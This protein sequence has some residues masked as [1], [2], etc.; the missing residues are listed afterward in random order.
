MK[1]I[2]PAFSLLFALQLYA[3]LPES[4]LTAEYTLTG[5]E[6][7]TDSPY[8]IAGSGTLN[9]GRD[10]QGTGTLNIN[11][12]S[13]TTNVFYGSGT[14]NVG[15][16]ATSGYLNITGTNP[17]FPE[18]QYKT[19]MNYSGTINVNSLGLLSING[20]I[21]SQWS[22]IVDIRNLNLEGMFTVS[23]SK[24]SVS[25]IQISNLNFYEGANL[26]SSQDFRTGANAVWNIYG[27]DIT[28]K[29]LRVG[30]TT[31][32]N[33]T[34]NLK[35][36][37]VLRNVSDVSMDTNDVTLNLNVDNYPN[38]LNKLSVCDDCML[39]INLSADR[40]ETSNLS[41]LSLTSK[42]A[43]ASISGASI[44]IENF[45]NDTI[46]IGDSNGVTIDENKIYLKDLDMYI[47]VT[48][49]AGETDDSQIFGDWSLDWNESMQLFALN[50]SAI[51]EPSSI[52]FIMGIASLLAARAK[53]YCGKRR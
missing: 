50:N 2:C 18:M 36:E 22:E 37:D 5:I 42:N 26:S 15:T 46:F 21:P 19:I 28:F 41:I 33:V 35:G 34:I 11:Y 3:E 45:A 43:V 38:T 13:A 30:N 12:S 47:S 25:Y 48:A 16:D 40:S 1:T 7:L 4:Q 53:A 31:A 20:Y 8:E 17:D 6:T 32:C 51:P 39:N 44:A 14:I 23:A 24:N 27:G 52:A 49:Y 10:A 29:T 9:I